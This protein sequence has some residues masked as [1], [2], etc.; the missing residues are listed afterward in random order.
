[1]KN[2]NAADH[3]SLSHKVG[4]QVM[5]N[6]IRRDVSPDMQ[7]EINKKIMGECMSIAGEDQS[8]TL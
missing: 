2:S 1:M 7:R 6:L 4:L 8:K 5:N 3:S